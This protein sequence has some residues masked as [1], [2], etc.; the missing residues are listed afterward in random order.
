MRDLKNNLDGA[1]SLAPASYTSTTNGS[2]ADLQGYSGAMLVF[3]AGTADTGNGDE[4]YTPSV[5]ESD[6]NSSF[7]AV[8]ASDLE[9]SLANMTAN[10]V[11]RAGYAFGAA[12][13]G[14]VANAA[15]LTDRIDVEA[16]RSIGFWLF[17]MVIPI[18]GLGL[19]AAWVF[20]RFP[21]PVIAGTKQ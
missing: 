5:E 4:T 9:G 13:L 14:L 16:A 2:G 21:L 10:T 1:N 12:Y 19:Y 20:I 6:D 3:H 11:Q 15:G 17:A 8:A 18:A 7:S